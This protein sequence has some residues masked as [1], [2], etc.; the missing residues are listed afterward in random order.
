MLNRRILR[1]KVFQVLYAYYREEDP[2]LAR[3]ENFLLSSITRIEEMYLFILNLPVDI[4]FYI[5]NYANPEEVKYFPSQRDIETG[6]TFV[7]SAPISKLQENIYFKDRLKK[8]RLNWQDNKDLLRVL[9]REF[10]GG[11]YFQ[12]Y[13]DEPVKDFA[14]QKK[15]IGNFFQSFLPQSDDFDQYMEELN[16]HWEDDKKLIFNFLGKSIENITETGEKNFTFKLSEDWEEDWNFARDLFRKTILNKEVYQNLITQKTEKWDSDRI[17]VSD[18]VLMKMALCEM[19]EFPSIPVKVTIN[20]YLEISKIYSTPKSN[21]F[22]NGILDKIKNE[23][24]A[25]N[26]IVKLGRGLVE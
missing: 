22:L 26:K 19:L 11:E 23:M 5:E 1:I 12:Q 18:M 15:L 9:F 2:V 24:V 13:L 25:D 20:E 21:S 10:K 4:K 17:A 14:A 8:V 3:H 6:R 16:M 7:Y